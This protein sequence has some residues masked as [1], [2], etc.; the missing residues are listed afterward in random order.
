ML[1]SEEEKK[2]ILSMH[3]DNGYKTINE[4]SYILME[5]NTFSG[6]LS[7]VKK[8]MT[9]WLDL[10]AEKTFEKYVKTAENDNRTF[11]QRFSSWIDQFSGKKVLTSTEKKLLGSVIQAQVRNSDS[12]RRNYVLSNIEKWKKFEKIKGKDWFK[13]FIVIN[14]NAE[15]YKI[16]EVIRDSKLVLSDVLSNRVKETI[17]NENVKIELENF[18]KSTFNDKNYSFEWDPEKQKQICFFVSQTGD[19]IP[20]TYLDWYIKGHVSGHE[21]GLNDNLSTLPTKLADGAEFRLKIKTIIEKDIPEF[22]LSKVPPMDLR[23]N[24]RVDTIPNELPDDLMN[25]QYQLLRELT[26]KC[27]KYSSTPFDQ[28]KIKIIGKQYITGR[29][30]F[31]IELP[32]GD[33]ILCYESSG[34]NTETTGKKNGEWFVIPGFGKL[35]ENGRIKSDT[36]FIKTPE[37]V[38]ITSNNQYFKDLDMYLRAIH[39]YQ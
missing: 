18:L 20:T 1:I 35:Y 33:K 23:E 24:W 12:F 38:K 25:R 31:E 11:S 27:D 30:V 37:N 36:W 22:D 2:R 39:G 29:N 6:L 14:F 3:I 32:K 4:S 15:T 17:K 34:S 28:T 7:K 5:Q 8:S 16:Y 9:K 21:V 13:K 26:E 19:K 10:N